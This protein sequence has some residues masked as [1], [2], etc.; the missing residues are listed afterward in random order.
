MTTD[1]KELMQELKTTAAREMVSRDT[2]ESTVGWDDIV[3]PENILALIEVLESKDA[4]IAELET[5]I[6]IHERTTVAAIER[7]E[8]ADR[9][10]V[11]LQSR[12][13]AAENRAV[14]VALPDLRQTVS[15]ERYAWSDGVYNY[16]QDVREILSA[17]GIKVKVGK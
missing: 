2:G 9:R 14:S 4:R 7:A 15:G 5:Y 8:M 6:E 12:A 11:E 16:A 10:A 1:I 13:E 17:T 3:T